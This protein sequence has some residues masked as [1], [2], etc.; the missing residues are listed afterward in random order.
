MPL[1][2]IMSL[3]KS[4]LS[5][6]QKQLYIH[7]HKHIYTYIL[8]ICVDIYVCIYKILKIL[9]CNFCIKTKIL[10][11]LYKENQIYFYDKCKIYIL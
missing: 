6:F 4:L 7:I 8:I 9:Y 5:I 11:R 1:Y 3:N 10:E 2:V